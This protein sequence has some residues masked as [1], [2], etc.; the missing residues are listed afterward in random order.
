MIVP[1][2][3]TTLEVVIVGDQG[4]VLMEVGAGIQASP[5]MLRLFDQ[6]G[7]S[8]M[9]HAKDI[10]LEN[11][12]IRRWKDG[13]VLSTMPVNK[14]YGQQTVVHRADLHNALITKALALENVQLKVNSRVTGIKSYQP[15]A[16]TLMDDTV[17][18]GDVVV[19]ADGIK[20]VLRGGML[21]P[22]AM[23]PIPTGDAAY[24]IMLPREMMEQDPE[25]KALLDNPS[26][27]RWIG[28][29]RHIIAYPVRNHE[30]FN[31]VLL[32]PDDHGAEESWTTTASKQSMLRHYHGWDTT[33][34]KLLDL[35][36]EDE[37]LEW[38][39]CSYPSL[40]SWTKG[41]VA[42][43]GDACH[44]MLPYVAQ[45]AAQAVEDAAALAI[46][47]SVIPSRHAIPEALR[48]YEKSRKPRAEAIQQ[49]GMANRTILHLP[50]GPEQEAR[51][52]QFL[53][54]KK[55][56]ANPDKWADAET[57]KRLWGWNAEEHALATWSENTR[58]VYLESSL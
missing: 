49:S 10:A 18:T 33:V 14:A 41:H 55:S 7:V 22:L 46:L 20:S 57:Q 5:N 31:I 53:A 19:A 3:K 1:Q 24:R 56:A 58:P 11:I 29:H 43:L 45:G 50:D 47:L 38:K 13:G 26:A 44:P 9:V 12:I 40:N 8:S 4:L 25:L 17:V 34:L 28:P 42:L 51:D 21:G 35:V 16:V 32:H 37:V 27:T 15:A 6:W 52:E 2:A 36:K 23:Q 30:L 54:S 39:L 48:V